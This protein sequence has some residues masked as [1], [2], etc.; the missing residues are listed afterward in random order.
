M[1]KLM[2]VL[3]L[4]LCASKSYA[5]GV[6]FRQSSF[7]SIALEFF[8]STGEK[9]SYR[10]AK[11]FSPKDDKFAVQTGRTDEEGR[12]AFVPDCVGEWRVIVRD[13]EGH[14][15]EAKIDIDD[16]SNLDMK[17]PEPEEPLYIRAILGVS[18]IF[19]IA[20]L[21]YRRKS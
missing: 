18:I 12:F 17:A 14:Q 16:V 10:E 1:K 11:V 5:H 21:I 2:F 20:M 7:R 19:N 8:Y 4:T 13:E 6:G 15:C 3:M 9:M